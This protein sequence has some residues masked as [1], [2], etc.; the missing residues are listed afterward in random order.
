MPQKPSVLALAFVVATAAAVVGA[1]SVRG[2]ENAMLA[3]PPSGARSE[4]LDFDG[5][6]ARKDGPEVMLRDREG[7]VVLLASAD[8]KEAAGRVYVRSASPTDRFADRRWT[9][10]STAAMQAATPLSAQDG[11]C[12]SGESC[13]AHVLFCCSS[14]AKPLAFC[15]AWHGCREP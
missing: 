10:S 12:E 1:C 13:I 11:A 6:I 15:G 7:H 8:V 14:P 9:A 3:S 4:W 2:R 5:T